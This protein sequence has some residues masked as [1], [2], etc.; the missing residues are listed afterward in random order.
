[1][2]DINKDKG[3]SEIINAYPEEREKSNL[4]IRILLKMLLGN[5]MKAER[6]IYL[7]NSDS[8]KANGYYNS[9]TD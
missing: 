2:Q 8:N 5:L 7:K 4:S 9:V 1:M 3:L 6:D